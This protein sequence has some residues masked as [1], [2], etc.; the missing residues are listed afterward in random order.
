MRR[1]VEE[2]PPLVNL[3]KYATGTPTGTFVDLLQDDTPTRTGGRVE[4]HVVTSK[5]FSGNDIGKNGLT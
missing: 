5:S 1:R 3:A 4:W 2:F